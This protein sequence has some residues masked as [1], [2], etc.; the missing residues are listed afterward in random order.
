MRVLEIGAGSGL[1]AIKVVERPDPTPGHG[2]VLLRMKAVSLNYR[3]LLSTLAVI[4]R[5]RHAGT[6]VRRYI[7]AQFA[8][9]FCNFFSHATIQPA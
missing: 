6:E 1:D 5:D 4:G 3:D 7:K 9:R 2:E 8:A